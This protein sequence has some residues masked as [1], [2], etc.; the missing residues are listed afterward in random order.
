LVQ[1]RY[2]F[3]ITL[4]LFV[5]AFLRFWALPDTPL[6]LH[7]DEATNV[8]IVRQIASGESLPIFIAAYTGKEVL[9][10]YWATLWFAL[11]GGA[12]W[13]L[14]LAGA[15]AGLLTVAATFSATR[16][17]LGKQQ[18]SYWIALFAAAWLAVAFPHVLLSHYSFRAIS[19][20][21]LEMLTITVLWRGWRT[22]G[23]AW[24]VCG[25]ILLGLTA[26][27]YLAARLFPIP[28]AL[29]IA[30]LIVRTPRH[31]RARRLGQ[32]A[33]A[34]IAAI[35]A[36]APLGIYFLNHPDTFSTRITQVAAPTPEE[37]LR[38]IWLCLQGLVVPGAGDPYIR[39]NSPGR[40]ILDPVFAVLA[41]I[42]L[43]SLIL[44]R[45]RGE[46]PSAGRLLVLIAPAVMLLPSALATSEITPSNL[47]LVGIYPFLGILV[48][49]G[50]AE[51]LRRI[52][53][54]PLRNG[55]ALSLFLVLGTLISLRAYMQWATSSD[56][57]Y[58]N[59][60][61]MVLAAQ[62]LDAANLDHATVYIAS[63]HYR[64]PT[65]AA[66]ARN[67]GKAKW[68]TGGSTL[69]L[70]AQ[71]DAL[72]LVPSTVPPPAAWPDVVRQH[73]Q[74]SILR[75]PNGSPALSI[76]RL[77]AQDIGTLRPS[78]SG[79]VA[80]FAHVVKVYAAKPLVPCH[81]SQSCPVMVTWQVLE[82]YSALQ[83]VLRLAHPTSGQWDRVN[84]FHYPTADWTT[85]DVILDQLSVTPP[86]GTPPIAGYQVGVSFF[87]PD[88]KEILP[89]L[90]K[91]R[92]AG[93]EATFPFGQI[94]P[95]DP[96]TA[97]ATSAIDEG[98]GE[99]PQQLY[100]TQSG[101]RLRASNAPP[102]LRPG[103]KVDVM[104][105]W[106]APSTHLADQPLQ[107]NLIGHESIVLYRGAPVQDSY[108]FSRWRSHELVIDRFSERIPRTV[109][110]GTYSLTLSVGDTM[111]ADLGQTTVPALAR[112]F[113]MPNPS[114][115]T[116][117]EFGQLIRL[118]G[119]DVGPARAGTPLQ[120][121]LYWQAF[122]ESEQDYTVFVHLVEPSSGRVVAQED[123][124]PQHGNYPL[125]LWSKGEFVR[126]EH[127]LGVP[128]IAP[129]I[130]DV[131][132]GLYR[133]DDGEHLAV[134]GSG[135]DEVTLGKIQL[136]Q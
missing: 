77:S 29:A 25:G 132:V 105:C 46:V 17:L 40:A 101:V 35:I 31:E 65:V 93:L 30:W 18:Y 64:H 84:P 47:R 76:Y 82:P 23:P 16:A 133:Q 114:H 68:L 21:L 118:V 41:I 1:K 24:L 63:L 12:Q 125:S 20:P 6:G 42:G 110:A 44:R 92:F 62:A 8:V 111:L 9:F 33:L 83:P 122:Q 115:V 131:R 121:V 10:F 103:E 127:M 96:N 128:V 113:G 37:A 112:N 124:Q 80:D 13:G 123:E 94:L 5:A 116:Q 85:G 26:Y 32:A 135:D 7:Y 129:G 134:S 50:V 15:C 71:G 51:L 86:L 22:A 28:L 109:S 61:E 126:D 87:N 39:F 91:E 100:S 3:G 27:T 2:L 78:G 106:Q 11:V 108:P 97:T 54:A 102:Q 104:L 99:L 52:P 136:Q 119:Y 79:P 56:L 107:L 38:G 66:L 58:A 55:I 57:F 95:T 74:M 70:P 34:L 48:G 19:L 81:V 75:A 120:V 88:T 36:F 53:M 60:G 59:D 130:Y 45:V 49:A 43:A 98:C 72:Y 14:R 117:A 69:V 4:V 89:L 90:K 73:W 67:Y